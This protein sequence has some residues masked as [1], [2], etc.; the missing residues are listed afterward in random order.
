LTL[1]HI[2]AWNYPLQVALW[3]RRTQRG[4]SRK[5]RRRRRR[6]RRRSDLAVTPQCPTK[7]RILASVGLF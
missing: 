5:R 7:P 2:G 3:K 6:R 1:L 4:R